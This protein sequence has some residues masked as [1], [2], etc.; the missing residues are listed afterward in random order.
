[1]ADRV[2]RTDE[3]AGALATLRA[4]IDAACRSAGRSPE[5]VTLIAVSKTFPTSD[6]AELAGLG[7]QDFGENRDQEAAAKAAEMTDRHLR[8]HFVGRLQRNKC[9]SVASYT[10]AVHALDRPELVGALSAGAGRAGRE[11]AALVQVSLD[12]DPLRGGVVPGGL[13]ALAAQVAGAPGLRLAGLMA[14]VPLGGAPG[15]CFERLAVLAEQVRTTHPGADWVSAGMS[16]DLEAAILAG[17]THVR[18]GTALFGSRGTL[19]R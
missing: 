2:S 8:W 6:V 18:V 13:E 15:P 10:T 17:A 16:S 5:D 12:G 11:V 7:V 19:L 14:V 1:M 3:L 4:R 9:R